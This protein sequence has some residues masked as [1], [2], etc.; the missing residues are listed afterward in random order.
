M[1]AH[2]LWTQEKCGRSW[3]LPAP[4]SFTASVNAS[5]QKPCDSF[6]LMPD[7]DIQIFRKCFTA[8]SAQEFFE[9]SAFNN[10]IK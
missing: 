4:H 2:F 1:S 10:G 9:A 5:R 6:S 8:V 3:E 7:K